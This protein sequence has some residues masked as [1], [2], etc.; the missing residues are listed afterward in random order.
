MEKE[1]KEGLNLL[2]GAIASVK[3]QAEKAYKEFESEFQI[4]AQ[5]GSTD[6]SE[7]SANLRKYVQEG[8]VQLETAYQNA[9]KQLDELST[10]LGTKK[11]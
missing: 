10:K 5:K 11:A 1:I 4:L 9:K 7:V 3:E 2:I 6:T 8:S